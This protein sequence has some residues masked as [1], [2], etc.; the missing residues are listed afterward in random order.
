MKQSYNLGIVYRFRVIY[1]SIDA[2][3]LFVY[4]CK[5]TCDYT[6]LNQCPANRAFLL[7]PR[8]MICWFVIDKYERVLLLS[9][10]T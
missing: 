1:I 3:I 9:A 6:F 4:I 5:K 2:W 10:P 8:I 7:Y